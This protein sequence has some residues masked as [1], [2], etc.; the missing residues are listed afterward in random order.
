[1]DF[2]MAEFIYEDILIEPCLNGK[3]L[4]RENSTS[5]LN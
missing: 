2:S 1:M 3:E 4:L 5:F